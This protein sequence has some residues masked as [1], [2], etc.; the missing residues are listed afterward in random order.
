MRP[1][2][3]IQSIIIAVCVWLC[4]LVSPS[5]AMPPEMPLTWDDPVIAYV[6]YPAGYLPDTQGR[7]EVENRGR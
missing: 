6:V 2:I 7:F 4:S 5:L 1:H 3:I